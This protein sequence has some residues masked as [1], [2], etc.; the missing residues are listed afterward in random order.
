MRHTP[1][2][3]QEGSDEPDPPDDEPARWL[4][5]LGDPAIAVDRRAR[6]TAANAAARALL[7]WREDE[8]P[9][10]LR[11][12]EL[13]AT[14][15]TDDRRHQAQ[16][17][18]LHTTLSGPGSASLT[19]TVATAEG[20]IVV[21]ATVGPREAEAESDR[22][23]VVLRDASER[24]ARERDLGLAA[25]TDHTT[26]LANRLGISNAMEDLAARDAPVTLILLDLDGFKEVN[27]R[28]GHPTGDA[29][30]RVMGD[31]L[32]RVLRE[33]DV[34][35][36]MGGD[37]FAALLPGAPQDVAAHVADRILQTVSTPIVV[38]G[39]RVRVG[40]SLGVST[41][42]AARPSLDALLS[43]ADHS[44]REAKVT[45]K[46]K[47][48]VAGRGPDDRSDV[49]PG[50]VVADA[51]AWAGHL[52]AVRA[53]IGQAKDDGRLPPQLAAPEN[54]HRTL[55]D[56][57]GT[58]DAL[59]HDAADIGATDAR[60]DLR[61]PPVERLVPFAI[62]VQAAMDW[63]ERLHAHGVIEAVRPP[64]ARRFWAA[65]EA[66]LDRLAWGRLA[67]PA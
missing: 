40:S 19:L 47:V 63:V 60:A 39:T 15:D 46:G 23:I 4:G 33:G 2:A 9:A 26:Q 29:V 30:L 17:A 20:P 41:T 5:L 3:G 37:E 43:E 54:V 10:T 21:D 57:M 35:A 34:A 42:H 25:R 24:L 62:Y 1:S 11:L 58:I 59:P 44:L 27:D 66:H 49:I 6:L 7:G 52:R 50:V 18:A 61:V 48:V 55:L 12:W 32:R 14:G 16:S 51:R 31:R 67:P 13:L 28:H 64:G 22:R 8:P 65:V 45:G 38:G 56:L 53:A 36:R